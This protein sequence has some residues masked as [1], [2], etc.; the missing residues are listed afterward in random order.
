MES[1]QNLIRA[2]KQPAYD[3]TKTDG[4]REPGGE[5]AEPSRQLPLQERTFQDTLTHTSRDPAKHHSGL[6]LTL[7]SPGPQGCGSPLGLFIRITWRVF[8]TLEAETAC[9]RGWVSSKALGALTTAPGRPVQTSNHWLHGQ[10][11][12]SPSGQ[13]AHGRCRRRAC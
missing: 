3:A 9:R 13:D 2:N 5:G 4:A 10:L 8:T 12:H 1:N 7:P 11:A 6:S